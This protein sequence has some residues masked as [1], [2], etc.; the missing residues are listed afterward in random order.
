MREIGLLRL[1]N[2]QPVGRSVIG[3]TAVFRYLK[4][5][6][7]IVAKTV[8]IEGF[9]VTEQAVRISSIKSRQEQGTTNSVALL[10]R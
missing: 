9:Q 3:K 7:R 10:A 6:L 2:H 4:S 5:L 8:F 1:A